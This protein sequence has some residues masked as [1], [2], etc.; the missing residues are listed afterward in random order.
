MENPKKAEKNWNHQCFKRVLNVRSVIF[1]F[2]PIAGGE[3]FLIVR[4]ARKI[5]LISLFKFVFLFLLCFIHQSI[6]I[7]NQSNIDQLKKSKKYDKINRT[8]PTDRTNQ[9][10]KLYLMYAFFPS[11]LSLLLS[12]CTVCTF[13]E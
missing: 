4:F 9:R 3:Q 8:E 5:R 7:V 6:S 2:I 11:E 13:S 10:Q 1:I 12:S